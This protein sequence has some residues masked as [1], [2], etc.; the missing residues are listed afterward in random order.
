M[1]TWVS[2]GKATMLEVKRL[3]ATFYFRREAW[4]E[5]L[6]GKSKVILLAND[7]LTLSSLASTYLGGNSDL[8]LHLA[9][10]D[11]NYL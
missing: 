2:I 4:V 6:S 9:I 11:L 1:F 10:G 8:Q 3:P 5:A 7:Q